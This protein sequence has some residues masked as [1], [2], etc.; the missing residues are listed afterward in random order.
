[1]AQITLPGRSVP[2]R[3]DYSYTAEF[4]V[5]AGQTLIEGGLVALNAAGYLVRATATTGLRRFGIFTADGIGLTCDNSAGANGDKWAKV[6]FGN[7]K[8]FNKAADLVTAASTAVA[9]EDD[10][11]VRATTAGS[12]TIAA[13]WVMDRD[14][15]LPWVFLKYE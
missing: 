13:T 1:M 3:G 7:F 5:A 11:T 12:S 14:D 8:F 6:K 15:G 10:Q 4:P 9:V 2:Q